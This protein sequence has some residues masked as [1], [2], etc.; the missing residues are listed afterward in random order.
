MSI[1]Q[2]K[3]LSKSNS[4]RLDR[5]LDAASRRLERDGLEGLTM[6]NLAQDSGVSPVTLYNRFGSKDNIVSL[7]VMNSFDRNID[8]NQRSVAQSESPFDH[9]LTL[10]ALLE[11]EL[12]DKRAFSQALMALYFKHDN[13]RE[14]PELMYQMLCKRVLTSVGDLRLVNGLVDWTPLEKLATELSDRI[15]G[16]AI[17]WAQKAITDKDLLPSMQ[18]SVLSALHVFAAPPVQERIG[19]FLRDLSTPPRKASSK[20]K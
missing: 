8:F 9:L 5:I 14:L 16:T 1:S 10:I 2:K 19:A 3:F 7:V 11:H 13:D 15:L 18:F 6:R 17:K 20:K 12:R 4:D